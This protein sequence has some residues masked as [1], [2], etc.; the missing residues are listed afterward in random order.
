MIHNWSS[1]PRRIKTGRP[2]GK[3]FK[4]SSDTNSDW[5]LVD[6]LRTWINNYRDQ[7]TNL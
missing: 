1:D 6:E 7:S 4:Y 3:S 5:M 2:V